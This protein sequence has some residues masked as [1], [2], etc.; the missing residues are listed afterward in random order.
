MV[1]PFTEKWVSNLVIKRKVIALKNI[2]ISRKNKKGGVQLPESIYE[3]LQL[4]Q[5]AD[6]SQKLSKKL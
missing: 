6:Y 1:M 3:Q 4:C 2:E 5:H